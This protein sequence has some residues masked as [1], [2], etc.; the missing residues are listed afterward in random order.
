MTFPRLFNTSA[1]LAATLLLFPL[2]AH[3]QNGVQSGE[4][5]GQY[6]SPPAPPASADGGQQ[7]LQQDMNAMPQDGYASQQEGYAGQ[8]GDP[9]ANPQ[10][11][12]TADYQ[13]NSQPTTSTGIEQAPP[14]IPD[15]EQPPAPGDGYIWT[16]GYWAWSGDGYEWVQGAWVAAP[17]TGALW[18]PGYWGYNPYGYFWNAGYWGPEVGYYG[19]INYGFGYFGVGFYGGYWGGGRFWYNRPYCNLGYGG[20]GYHVYEHPYNGFSGRPGGASYVRA[21]F[22]SHGGGAYANNYRDGFRGSTINGRG[23]TQ[24]HIQQ[25]AGQNHG[26][27]QPGAARP[28]YG[29]QPGPARAGNFGTWNTPQNTSRGNYTQA[30]A[31]SNFSAPASNARSYNSYSGAGANYAPRSYAPPS[32]PRGN[33]SA[34]APSGGSYSGGSHAAP[35]APAGG[36]F[37]GGGG[38]GSP[39]G[40][41]SGG[42]HGGG[43]H[44]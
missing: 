35:S 28:Q 5:N 3:A 26:I 24:S 44:R 33:Y 10:D 11:Q 37:H 14:P 39:G 34:P 12:S 20:R 36:G 23:F 4:N 40:G 6:T 7:S 17:Y 16:P 27:A 31:R 25:N 21:N 1:V 2:M 18:T 29:A 22:T 32:Q 30:P 8:Q 13:N 19:D 15:Y 42:S 41:G 9:Y 43:G 38:G